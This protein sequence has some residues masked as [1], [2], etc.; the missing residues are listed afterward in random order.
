[1]T[2]LV[3][4]GV[5]LAGGVGAMAR[6]VMDA[7]IRGIRR[8]SF[9]IATGVINVLGSLIAGV[10]VGLAA[11]SVLADTALLIAGTGFLGG[12]T[13]FSTASVETVRLALDG[14]WTLASLNAFGVLVATVAAAALG[15]VVVIALTT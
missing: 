13:T 2:P 6:F 4:V 11:S 9:P 7:A 3:F 15:Y 1:M 5:C 14:R 12:Y 8:T 10:L